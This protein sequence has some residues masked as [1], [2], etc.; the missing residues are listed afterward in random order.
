MNKKGRLV[1]YETIKKTFE[2]EKEYKFDS[3]NVRKATKTIRLDGSFNPT[4]GE[5]FIRNEFGS[6]SIKDHV[7]LAK[8]ILELMEIF[9][10]DIDYK[11]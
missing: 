9:K 2:Y 4:T 8:A 3:V 1:K 10:K 6:G 11:K 7:A 5:C